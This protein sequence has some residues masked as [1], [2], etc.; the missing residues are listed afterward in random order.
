MNILGI[1]C[2]PKKGRH[3]D[4]LVDTVAAGA[5]GDGDTYEKIYINDLKFVPCQDCGYCR[6]VNGCC[7]RDDMQM[8]YDRL[9][10]ADGIIVGAPTY[11]GSL[12]A[13]AKMFIDRC[14]R[15]ID[16]VDNGDETWTFASRIPD[17]KYLVF[18]GT[19]GSFGPD[20]VDGQ[21]QVIRH[22][23]NDL[24][25]EYVGDVFGHQ[26]DYRPVAD[27]DELLDEARRMGNRLAAAIGSR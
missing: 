16:Y 15:F 26:T 3:T 27:H 4:T 25:A 9:M 10:E 6:R 18:A 1:V 24:N 13:Q 19:N 8:V 5:L 20:C 17:R 14:N 11:Y 23:C 12:N 21:I 7:Y 22:L 2:S